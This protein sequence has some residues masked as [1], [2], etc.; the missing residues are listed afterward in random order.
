[1]RTLLLMPLL[2]TGCPWLG[3]SSS[4]NDDDDNSGDEGGLGQGQGQGQGG[5]LTLSTLFGRY[6]QAICDNLAQCD[7]GFDQNYSSLNDCVR[8]FEELFFDTFRDCDVVQT[9]AE[10]CLNTIEGNL[11]CSLFAETI[12][13]PACEGIVDCPDIVDTGDGT[14]PP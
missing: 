5:T 1:M 9:Q 12:V 3:L 10:T 8:D 2:L 11:N 13:P 6:S 4:D 14:S 7:G